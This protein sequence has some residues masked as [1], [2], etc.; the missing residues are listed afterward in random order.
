MTDEK[1]VLRLFAWNL[2]IADKAKAGLASSAKKNNSEI[3]AHEYLDKNDKG[4]AESAWWNS[5]PSPNSTDWSNLLDWYRNY[6]EKINARLQEHSIPNQKEIF[7]FLLDEIPGRFIPLISFIWNQRI[8]GVYENQRAFFDKAVPCHLAVLHEGAKTQFHKSCA[9]PIM[10]FNKLEKIQT[11]TLDAPILLEG[12]T[13]TG[14]S[15]FAESLHRLILRSDDGFERVNLA[16]LSD[17]SNAF[18]SRI[19]GHVKGSFTGAIKDKD[20]VLRANK[21]GTVFFDELDGLSMSN[22]IRLL[23]YTDDSKGD[24]FLYQPR[25]GETKQNRFKRCNMIFATNRPVAL[26]LQE[27]KLRPDFLY[28]F[29]DRVKFEGL[30]E[31]FNKSANSDACIMVYLCFFLMKLRP[32]VN[33]S[34]E[35]FWEMPFR[36]DSWNKDAFQRMREFHWS[37]NFRTIDKFCRY[38]LSQRAFS[39]AGFLFLKEWSAWASDQYDDTLAHCINEGKSSP[40]A[41]KVHFP[42]NTQGLPS[43][44]VK[45]YKDLIE[46]ALK[47]SCEKDGKPNKTKAAELLGIDTRTLKKNIIDFG[48]SEVKA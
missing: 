36:A 42:R 8:I 21:F 27:G 14:K 20:G 47:L 26:A 16:E 40:K 41:E 9:D 7:V 45:R 32:L 29:R 5:S 2:E 13:G 34:P 46:L 10:L 43:E 11:L 35:R 1:T 23:T 3:K 15:L 4:L 30:R 19:V 18:I 12:P 6:L 31:V 38:L 37:G 17:D 22:Q 39:K 48:A 44:I 28:R 24:G 25:L 33:E